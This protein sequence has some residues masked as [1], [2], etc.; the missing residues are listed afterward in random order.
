MAFNFCFF[1][2]VQF[3]E[4]AASC[5]ITETWKSFLSG[6]YIRIP[7][8]EL[9]MHYISNFHEDRTLKFWGLSLHELQE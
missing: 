6:F 9:Y 7:L 4:C 5:G 2:I 8:A 1:C 3:N